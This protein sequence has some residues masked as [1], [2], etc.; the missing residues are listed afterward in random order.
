MMLAVRPAASRTLSVPDVSEACSA[1]VS[2]VTEPLFTEPG[3]AV[4]NGDAIVSVSPASTSLAVKL[5]CV[6]LADAPVTDGPSL[7][8]LMAIVKV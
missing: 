5:I 1:T 2:V 7:T 4:P 8:L 3:K 6:S